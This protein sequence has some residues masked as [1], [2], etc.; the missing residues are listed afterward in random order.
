MY[1]GR[2][3]WYK[4][5]SGSHIVH[6]ERV[7]PPTPKLLEMPH[8]NGGTNIAVKGEAR[9][10]ATQFLAGRVGTRGG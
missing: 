5:H 3:L 6:V 2:E 9:E 4:L 10:A 7:E 1:L 8:N